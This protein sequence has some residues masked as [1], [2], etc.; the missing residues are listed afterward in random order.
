MKLSKF[1]P[2][3]KVEFPY[4]Y[5]AVQLIK[6]VRDATYVKDLLSPFW[7]IP[8]KSLSQFMMRFNLSPGCLYPECMEFLDKK[9]FSGVKVEVKS[10]RVK[11]SG[12][13]SHSFCKAIN[14]VCSIIEI[15]QTEDSVTHRSSLGEIIYNHNNIVVYKFPP[16]LYWRV[17]DF[18]SKCGVEVEIHPYPAMPKSK[19]HK[20]NIAPR[21]YQIGTVK[22]ILSG[23]IPNRA[24]LCMAT[25][26]GKTIMSAMITAALG[27]KTIFYTYSTDLLTQTIKEYGN[28]F[29]KKIGKIG[30]SVFDLQDITIATIQTVIS[31]YEMQDDRWEQLANHFND[32]HLMFID[33]GHMLG[34]D[35]V[36]K[37]SQITNSYYSYALTATPER[38]DGKEL[39]IEAGA[40]PVNIVISEDQ[41]VKEGYILPVVVQMIRYEHEKY[42]GKRYNTLYK[43]NIVENKTRNQLIVDAINRNKSKQVIVLVRE[44]NHGNILSG[45]LNAPFAHGK[46]KNRSELITSF[47]AKEIKVLVA[48]AILKQGVDLPDAEVLVLAD[49]GSSKVEIIQKIGRVRRPA[50]GKTYSYIIDILDYCPSSSSD[51]FLR[52]STRRL[53]IYNEQ[54]YKIEA[55][56]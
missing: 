8:P 20:V 54:K 33:E 18:I 4:N 40:G 21:H 2:L 16:G 17:L 39:L 35:T 49:G 15:E 36:Y 44:I 31:C 52:Q 56:G 14:D 53:K 27:Y 5:D 9:E 55:E 30:D 34:A 11:M 13:A 47:K 48:S 23:K 41:L 37:V 22:K 42:I 50:E 19:P 3:I 45:M 46:S 29:G 32:V 10:D 26:G 38:E 28:I 43:R 51:I 1:G 6:K 7:T 25:G 12:E 24:T